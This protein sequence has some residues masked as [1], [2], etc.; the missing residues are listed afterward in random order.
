MSLS[1]FFYSTKYLDLRDHSMIL[2][3]T[4]ISTID[5]TFH[6]HRI[7]YP[8]K[9]STNLHKFLFQ[10]SKEPPLDDTET[11][12]KHLTLLVLVQRRL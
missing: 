10:K 5:L 2:W 8:L 6:V 3:S 1:N 4:V 9:S 12:S 11:A 7:A